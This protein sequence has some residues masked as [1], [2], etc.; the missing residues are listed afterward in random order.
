M[1]DTLRI[2]ANSTISSNF[3]S[4]ANEVVS[5]IYDGTPEDSPA[6]KLLVDL[7][8]AR[9]A[10]QALNTGHEILPK[11][12]LLDLARR[13]ISPG[14]TQNTA[15]VNDHCR[16]HLHGSGKACYRKDKPSA[17]GTAV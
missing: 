17:A 10:P 6:R 9:L 2:R 12:F 13:L 11:E 3:T 8:K 16:H 1:L 5:I 14:D 7:Y 15:K 4:S